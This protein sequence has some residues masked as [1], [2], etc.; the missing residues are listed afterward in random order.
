M[1]LC[2][3]ASSSP[4][5]SCAT[6]QYRLDFGDVPM[7]APRVRN[8]SGATLIQDLSQYGKSACFP[9]WEMLINGYEN[10]RQEQADRFLDEAPHDGSLFKALA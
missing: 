9:Y 4:P 8:D 2:V 10:Y 1:K 5:V 3:L 7:S 6:A